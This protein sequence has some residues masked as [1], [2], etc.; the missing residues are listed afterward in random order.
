MDRLHEVPDL[1]KKILELCRKYVSNIDFIHG[2]CRLFGGKTYK[3]VNALL[4]YVLS[5]VN[6][7]IISDYWCDDCDLYKPVTLHLEAICYWR[8]IVRKLNS[9]RADCEEHRHMSREVL[10]LL[11][12]LYEALPAVCSMKNANKRVY[13]EGL[14][15]YLDVMYDPG[16]YLYGV[17][18]QEQ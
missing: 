2:R 7:D 14:R 11:N 1:S 12:I 3:D 17:T 13:G 10:K 4:K 18:T 6:G 15:S 5:V 8:G 9:L 16:K